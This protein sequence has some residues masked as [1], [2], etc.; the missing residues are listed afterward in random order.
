MDGSRQPIVGGTFSPK[1]RTYMFLQWTVVLV[2]TIVGIVL[3]PVWLI[4]GPIYIRRYH[5]AL[6]CD[7][8]ERSVVV[9]KGLMFR[10]ELTIPLDKIQDISI[11]EGPLLSALGLLQL[12]IE[13][14]GQSNTATGKSDADLIGLVDARALRDRILAQRDRLADAD[15]A[16]QAPVAGDTALLA[17]IRD[18]LMRIEASLASRPPAG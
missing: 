14:A 7:L 10:R 16:P 12:R 15:R 18:T 5:A 11:R 9:G 6:R 13:T 1:L 3:L 17:D 8:T 4:A 2:C